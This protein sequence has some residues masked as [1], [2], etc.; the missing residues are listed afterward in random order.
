[1]ETSQGL[2]ARMDR[3]GWPLLI[4]RLVVGGLFLK[5][6]F[7]KVDDPVAFL[8][9]LREYELAPADWPWALNALAISIP[10]LELW[11]AALL[12]LGVAVR[13]VSLAL[14]GL[15]AVFTVAVAVRA[16]GIAEADAV[17]LCEVAFDC[18]CGSGVVRACAKV[19][20]NLGLMLLCV[21]G[22]V[23]RSRR[24]CL[25]PRLAGNDGA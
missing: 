16:L 5:M 9:L 13:G 17:P 11:L 21:V 15:L 20:E 14:L 23:S 25:R 10:W 19:P 22:L 12:L 1:M 24:L 3:S 18:G 7:A 6:G 8:K 4:A 2:L